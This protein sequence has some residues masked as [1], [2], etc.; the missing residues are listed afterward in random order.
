[1]RW[2]WSKWGIAVGCSKGVVT[3]RR[4]SEVQNSSLV[5]QSIDV[6]WW[7]NELSVWK[8][9]LSTAEK[10][11]Q[12]KDMGPGAYLFNRAVGLYGRLGKLLVGS[13]GGTVGVE[14]SIPR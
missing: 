2:R 9:R 8:K 6:E 14:K 1:M 5:Q 10:W 13:R 12:E 11:W 4:P 7:V 3:G